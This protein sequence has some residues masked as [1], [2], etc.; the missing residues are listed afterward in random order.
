MCKLTF[1]RLASEKHV[2]EGKTSI[3]K[4]VSLDFSKNLE[5]SATVEAL[6]NRYSK[7]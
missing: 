5:F 2:T 4:P 3:I 1:L 7:R 6:I